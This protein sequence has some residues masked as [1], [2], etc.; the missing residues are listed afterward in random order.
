VETR[1]LHY[2][3]QIAELGSLTRAAGM[4][5]IAQP[6][7][8]RQMRL[9]EEELGVSLFT[10][11]P[12][13]MTLTLDGEYLRGCVAGPLREL[14]V[15]LQGM[16]SRP[17]AVEAHFVIGMPPGLAEALAECV[18]T[19]MAL[20][21]PA[22][23]FRLIEGPTGSLEDWLGRGLVDFAVLEEAPRDDRLSEQRIAVLPMGLIGPPEPRSGGESALLPGRSVTLDDVLRLPLVL[24]SHHIGIRGAIEDAAK[25]VRS[26]PDV[27]FE[28]DAARL[29]RDL[30]MRGIGYAILPEAYARDDLREGRLCFWPIV[31]PALKLEIFLASR[32]TSHA[33]GRQA[34]EVEEAITGFV[35]VGLSPSR[36]HA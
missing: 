9:L 15:A 22:I 33:A 30:V 36:V 10:R 5:R 2:F 12:R 8:S 24:P 14:E 21:F 34:R 6:A 25:S 26:K 17:S 27:R 19:G 35:A 4:L 3:I 7:L 32:R 13:G 18:A 20:R 31:D 28:A 23:R 29:M 11:T 1:R 16:R